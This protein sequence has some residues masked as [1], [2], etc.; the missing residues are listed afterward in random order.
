MYGLDP[1]PDDII[2]DLGPP[3]GGLS[4]GVVV[5]AESVQFLGR[6]GQEAQS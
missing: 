4:M 1:D 2:S 6:N 5:I 3:R